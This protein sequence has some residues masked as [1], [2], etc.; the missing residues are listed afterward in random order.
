MYHSLVYEYSIVSP[1]NHIGPLKDK[2]IQRLGSHVSD[3]VP[4]FHEVLSLHILSDTE[5]DTWDKLSYN[6]PSWKLS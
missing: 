2:L 5:E 1:E 6:V 3:D 4:S